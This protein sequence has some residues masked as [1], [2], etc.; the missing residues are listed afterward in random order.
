MINKQ[1]TAD[2][3][4]DN[5]GSHILSDANAVLHCLSG[6]SPSIEHHYVAHPNHY[7][8]LFALDLLISPLNLNIRLVKG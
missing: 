7:Y 2:S 8:D 5:D 3:A 1:I 6:V 4:Y